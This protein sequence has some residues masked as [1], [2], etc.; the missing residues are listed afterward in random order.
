MS[1]DDPRSLALLLAMARWHTSRSTDQRYQA[2]VD[3]KAALAAVEAGG[4]PPERNADSTT[5]CPE[6]TKCHAGCTTAADLARLRAAHREL[7]EAVG[8][9]LR[10]G[11]CLQQGGMSFCQDAID[12]LRHARI[13]AS[14]LE[15]PHG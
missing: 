15:E 8:L 14:A 9:F 1:G 13:A 11:A 3:I 10:G 5:N 7:G 6:P 2:G 4:A 12:E